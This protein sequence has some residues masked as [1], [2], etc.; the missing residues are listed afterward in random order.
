MPSSKDPTERE[1]GPGESP[2]PGR[3]REQPMMVMETGK[4][5]YDG[6]T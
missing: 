5:H 2:M 1:V 4:N 3:Q 6:K